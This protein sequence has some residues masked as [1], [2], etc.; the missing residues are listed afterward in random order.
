MCM[1]ICR[2]NDLAGFLAG[3]FGVGGGLVI[4][5]ALHFLYV[6]LGYSDDVSIPLA[7]GTAMSCIIINALSA[8]PIHNKNKAINWNNY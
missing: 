8:I 2:I 5:P 4:V 1:K 3:F 7:L 6:S